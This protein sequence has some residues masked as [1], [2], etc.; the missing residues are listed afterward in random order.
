MA[1]RKPLDEISAQIER[2]YSRDVIFASEAAQ[3]LLFD[4]EYD[5][6]AYRNDG[7]IDWLIARLPKLP[8][9]IRAEIESYVQTSDEKLF[10]RNAHI[11]TPFPVPDGWKRIPLSVRSH[12]DYTMTPPK[13]TVFREDDTSYELNASNPWPQIVFALRQYFTA[14]PE[15][16]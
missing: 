16:A 7:Q 4:V 11:S 9:A 14:T 13:I 5:I 8:E 2:L 10:V 15:N 1:D 12:V 3:K 6:A